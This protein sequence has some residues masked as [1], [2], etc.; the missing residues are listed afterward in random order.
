MGERELDDDAVDF[1]IGVG[2]FDF[3]DDFVGGF[4]TIIFD[5]DA[6]VCAVL[7]FELD[8][9]GDDGVIVVAKDKEPGCLT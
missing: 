5:Y 9:F 3:G 7:D 8:V 2:G 6:D 4:G 1:T